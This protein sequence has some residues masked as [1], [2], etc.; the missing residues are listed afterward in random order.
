MT[1]EIQNSFHSANSAHPLFERLQP[2]QKRAR[3]VNRVLGFHS[4][5]CRVEFVFSAGEQRFF[6]ERAFTPPKRCRVPGSPK[7]TRG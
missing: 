5:E 7:R 4:V 1:L 6:A 3:S 2:Q